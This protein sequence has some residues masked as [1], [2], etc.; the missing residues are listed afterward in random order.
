MSA[1]ERLRDAASPGLRAWFR[2]GDNARRVVA[3]LRRALDTA[4]GVAYTSHMQ[5]APP[6][7]SDRLHTYTVEQLRSMFHKV[8]LIL[9]ADD[10][11]RVICIGHRE[12]RFESPGTYGT[13]QNTTIV[14]DEWVAEHGAWRTEAHAPALPRHGQVVYLDLDGTGRRVHVAHASKFE[15]EEYD[16]KAKAWEKAGRPSGGAPRSPTLFRVTHKGVE[17]GLTPSRWYGVT[18]AVEWERVGD[19]RPTRRA[20]AAKTADRRALSPGAAAALDAMILHV[21]P[22]AAGDRTTYSLNAADLWQ[23]LTENRSNVFVRLHNDSKIGEYP[24][25][26]AFTPTGD[27]DALLDAAEYGRRT[28]ERLIAASLRR[29]LAGKWIAEHYRPPTRGKGEYALGYVRGP[30]LIP[31][32]TVEEL[33]GWL[34][35]MKDAE[36]AADEAEK[37]LRARSGTSYGYLSTPEYKA[38]Q[39]A[40]DAVRAAYAAVKHPA[41]EPSAIPALRA[42]VARLREAVSNVPE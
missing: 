26:V 21:L 39:N 33:T 42:A 11:A 34:S 16:K 13:D 6:L 20:E 37:R 15:V 24:W 14:P 18:N 3:V 31:R 7:A 32:A 10:G 41:A 29:L 38:I 30:K 17:Y 23:E 28:G 2:E 40:R 9:R 4:R 5:T 27:D 35:P 8:G 19:A 36:R 12:W 22:D 25:E 1:V